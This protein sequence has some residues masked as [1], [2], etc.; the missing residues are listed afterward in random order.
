[1]EIISIKAEDIKLFQNLIYYGDYDFHND[2]ECCKILCSGSELKLFFENTKKEILMIVFSN[3]TIS[4]IHQSVNSRI[5]TIDILYRGR[6]EE[7]NQLKEYSEDGKGYFYLSF[8]N[9]EE[10]QF[11]AEE[12]K[13]IKKGIS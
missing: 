4:E 9:D 5:D 7:N 1:M 11:W 13:I 3:V 10:I 6:F 8:Y 2:Y 12:F